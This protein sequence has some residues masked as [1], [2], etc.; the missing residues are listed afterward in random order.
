MPPARVILD[1]PGAGRNSARLEPGPP[2]RVIAAHR[3]EDVRPALAAMDVLLISSD[4]P[5]IIGMSD[6]ILVMR[7]GRY[8]PNLTIK[9]TGRSKAYLFT[10]SRMLDAG[11]DFDWAMFKVG[12][13]SEPETQAMTN[14]ITQLRPDI[15][16]WYHQDLFRIS[17]AQRRSV[18]DVGQAE[19]DNSKNQQHRPTTRVRGPLPS[20]W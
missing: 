7:A 19:L 18:R 3:L 4:L 15:A 13:A 20:P 1:F 16:L 14:F 11:D 8:D 17:P 2:H 5:E 9:I 6:R 12:P 10:P